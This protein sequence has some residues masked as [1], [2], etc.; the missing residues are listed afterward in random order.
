M[1]ID[2]ADEHHLILAGIIALI[3]KVLWDWLLN[4]NTNGKTDACSERMITAIE[5][6][7]DMQE[8]QR[9]I[10]DSLLAVREHQTLVAKHLAVRERDE[11]IE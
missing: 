11:G 8:R 7:R 10:W 6:L 3:G 2:F 1:Q 9:K 5:I 4:R